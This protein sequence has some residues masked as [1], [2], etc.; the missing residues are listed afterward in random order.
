MFADSNNKQF[1]TYYTLNPS[2]TKAAGVD[3][4]KCKWPLTGRLWINPPFDLLPQIIDLIRKYG[5]KATVIAPLMKQEY[6]SETPPRTSTVEDELL[7]MSSEPPIRIPHRY[8]V[9][10]ASRVLCIPKWEMT[11]AWVVDGKVYKNEL[12]ILEH[13]L[14]YQVLHM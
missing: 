9:F 14:D 7:R 5:V 3:S 12:S 1:A 10:Q 8:D 6:H 11:M 13:G 4:M 2:D